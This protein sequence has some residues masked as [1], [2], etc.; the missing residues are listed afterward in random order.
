MSPD[1]L[2][3]EGIGI[4]SSGIGKD[5]FNCDIVPAYVCLFYFIVRQLHREFARAG[6]DVIQAFT[7]SMDDNLESENA[8]YGVS[9]VYVSI[10]IC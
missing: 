2:R 8:K 4:L 5:A 9:T 3:M 10:Y 1:G 7:F 6:S